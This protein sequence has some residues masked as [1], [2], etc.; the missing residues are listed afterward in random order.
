MLNGTFSCHLMILSNDFFKEG[1][2][3]YADINSGINATL[4]RKMKE[5]MIK[6]QLKYQQNRVSCLLA[7][8]KHTLNRLFKK[9]LMSL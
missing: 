1:T 3:K 4:S 2:A 9:L 6:Q 5:K 7:P 8:Y